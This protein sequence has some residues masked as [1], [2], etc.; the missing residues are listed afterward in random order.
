MQ[1]EKLAVTVIEGDAQVGGGLEGANLE[2][3]PIIV[4]S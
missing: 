4:P 1:M 2:L 3:F